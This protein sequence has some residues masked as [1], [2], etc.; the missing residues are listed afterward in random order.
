MTARSPFVRSAVP[1]LS[2]I[3]AAAAGAA[4]HSLFGYR[5]P[6]ITFFPAVIFSAWFGGFGPGLVATFASAGLV[7]YLWFVPL[8]LSHASNPGDVV[9]L[10]LFVSIGLVISSVSESMHRATTQQAAAREHAEG[11]AREL[12][13]SEQRLRAALASEHAARAEAELANHLKDRFVATVSHE[14]RTPLNALLGWADMLKRNVLTDETRRLR[15][16]EA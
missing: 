14:L 5:M 3:S 13:D 9:A 4:L 1:V 8:L 11:A 2:A 6:L 15:A 10:L 7:A 16:V 12:R